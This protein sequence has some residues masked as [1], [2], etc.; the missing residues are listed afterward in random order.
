MK[1]NISGGITGMAQG[2][3]LTFIIGMI[4]WKYGQMA[5]GRTDMRLGAPGN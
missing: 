4:F 3:F 5:G 2:I 1:R